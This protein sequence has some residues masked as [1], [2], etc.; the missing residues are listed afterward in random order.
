[1]L[2]KTPPFAAVKLST[3]RIPNS[4]QKE[5]LIGKYV[6]VLG[7]YNTRSNDGDWRAQYLRCLPETEQNIAQDEIVHC[8][9]LHC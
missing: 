5:E 7:V 3:L 8:F 1:M 6:G 9:V 4:Q 2:L